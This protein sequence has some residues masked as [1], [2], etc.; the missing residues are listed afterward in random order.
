MSAPFA[1]IGKF[2]IERAAVELGEPRCGSA[3]P[4]RR[5]HVARS[6]ASVLSSRL[7]HFQYDRKQFTVLR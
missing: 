4:N 3:S 6:E 7:T 2:R 5:P 1:C